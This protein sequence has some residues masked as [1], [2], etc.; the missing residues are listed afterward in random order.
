MGSAGDRLNCF[1]AGH[2]RRDV[3]D[4]ADGQGNGNDV[5]FKHGQPAGQ[6]DL[7]RAV[8]RVA[9]LASQPAG[10]RVGQGAVVTDG[11]LVCAGDRVHGF[12]GNRRVQRR[13]KAVDHGT[14]QDRR[15][16]GQPKGLQQNRQQGGQEQAVP[17]GQENVLEL[18]ELCDHQVA[19]KAA[20]H[21]QCDHHREQ[22]LSLGCDGL[23][24]RCHALQTKG[25]H[26]QGLE[27]V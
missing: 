19:D 10:K 4:H 23:G 12:L 20:H 14:D 2:R 13:R 1:S 8:L 25:C 24:N 7:L 11:D 27:S 15:H 9:H 3:I 5:I 6:L 26:K 21:D 18:G 17:A 22:R 16:I